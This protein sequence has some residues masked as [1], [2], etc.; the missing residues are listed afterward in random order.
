MEYNGQNPLQREGETQSAN[1]HMTTRTHTFAD[2]DGDGGTGKNH[3]MIEFLSSHK[4][5]SQSYKAS[6]QF[7]ALSGTSTKR[8]LNGVSLAGQ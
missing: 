7:W 1:R 2:P 4:E 6:I 8:H 3:K 5:K